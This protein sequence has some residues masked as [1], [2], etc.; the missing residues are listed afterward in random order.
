MA[1]R[2]RVAALMLRELKDRAAEQFAEAGETWRQQLMGFYFPENEDTVD[3]C[4]LAVLDAALTEDGT[5]VSSHVR[6]NVTS[7]VNTGTLT[8][9]AIGIIFLATA[10]PVPLA[11]VSSA[12]GA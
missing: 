1:Q 2:G 5:T 3:L 8:E 6:R 12:S 4:A 11:K 7:L 10:Q 9:D